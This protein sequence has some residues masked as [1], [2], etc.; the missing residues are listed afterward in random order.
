MAMMEAL[1]KA[2]LMCMLFPIFPLIPISTNINSSGR[3][4]NYSAA[5]FEVTGN[6]KLQN[7]MISFGII[8]AVVSLLTLILIKKFNAMQKVM[9]SSIKPFVF[10]IFFICYQGAG[11]EEFD[12][13]KFA[14]MILLTIGIFWYIYLDN[15]EI[16]TGIK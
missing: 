5:L 15:E 6:D 13:V 9:L 4:E 7:L 3:L 8:S 2:V 1:W 11:H 14:G 16:A 12:I 10:W